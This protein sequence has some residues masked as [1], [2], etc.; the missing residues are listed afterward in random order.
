M[1]SR[2]VC[3]SIKVE[4]F[5]STSLKTVG[6][7]NYSYFMESFAIGVGTLDGGIL[8]SY[9]VEDKRQGEFSGTSPAKDSSL[10][11]NESDSDIDD[12][13][14]MLR[15]SAGGSAKVLGPDK[16]RALCFLN[17]EELLCEVEGNACVLCLRLAENAKPKILISIIQDSREKSGKVKVRENDL[18]VTVAGK[19]CGKGLGEFLGRALE[20]KVVGNSLTRGLSREIGEYIETRGKDAK[21]IVVV[22]KISKEL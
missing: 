7:N 8:G 18:V 15:D 1:I 22:A 9:D 16:A 6:S 21:A 19:I 5:F 3:F 10:F 2:N 12:L 17:G 20:K 4:F 14:L 11:G 13:E